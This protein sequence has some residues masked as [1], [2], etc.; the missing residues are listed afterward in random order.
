MQGMISH[1]QGAIDMAKVAPQYGKDAEVRILAEGVV[2]AQEGE[3]TLTRD[4]L[5]KTD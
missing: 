1:L 5:G 4:R 2:K 3:V